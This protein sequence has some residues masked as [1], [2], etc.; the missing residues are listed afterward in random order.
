MQVNV[1]KFREVLFTIYLALTVLV[2]FS[3]IFTVFSFMDELLLLISFSYML[4]ECIILKSMSRFTLITLLYLG[5]CIALALQSPFSPNIFYSFF[6][7][8]IH[9]KVLVI[10]Y[11][12]ITIFKNI[13]DMKLFLGIF[14]LLV[15][16]YFIAL[17]MNM[18]IGE[19][20]NDLVGFY[21]Y[22]YRYG[23]LR[24]AGIFSH[25]APN[26]YFFTLIVTTLMLT[27]G[28]SKANVFSYHLKKFVIFIF[29][30]F[31]AAFPLTVRKGMVVLIP[32]LFYV[33]AIL[34]PKL[35][36]II[37]MV[38]LISISVLIWLISET[39]IFIDTIDNF[40]NFFSDD[41]SYLRGLIVYYGYGLFS[42]FFPLGTGAGLYG[43]VF[44]NSNLSV[45]EYVGL[46]MALFTADDGSLIGVYDSGL[47]AL[48][49][50][51]GFIGL[52]FVFSLTYLL[53]DLCSKV[54]SVSNFKIIKLL[55]VYMLL[56]SITEPV[57]QNG[58]FTVF[59]CI[60]VLYVIAHE[61][62]SC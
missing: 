14:K 45:Y 31:F 3:G 50:E 17:F 55:T 57:L 41:H 10:S 4:F 58:F 42:D 48:A 44:S 1:A 9:I 52:L 8:L 39:Q 18:L 7:S 49:A 30:D 6:Q 13:V 22:Q 53:M 36:L 19:A 12:A 38:M 54:T 37:S 46:N 60:S 27:L 28:S 21:E 15:I 62:R 51:L 23:F 56:L 43:T 29:I 40:S 16:M 61:K 33:I 24:P 5:Y 25:Y 2:Y 32:Y 34:R 47:A 59:Y 11:F 26:S 20:W 35:K